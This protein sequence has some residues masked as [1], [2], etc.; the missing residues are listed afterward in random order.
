MPEE[1]T[2]IKDVPPIEKRSMVSENLD[3][4]AA[5][6]SVRKEMEK[7]D[8]MPNTDTLLLFAVEKLHDIAV[9]TSKIAE[10]VDIF[11]K[12]NMA[13]QVAPVQAKPVIPPVATPFKAVPVETPTDASPRLLE[14]MKALNK[15]KD[16][17]TFD[18]S[19]SA[20]YIFVK[21]IRKVDNWNEINQ[22]VKG[23]GGSYGE[24]KFTI[25]KIISTPTATPAPQPSVPIAN[26]T[27]I[28]K[29]KVNLKEFEDKLNFD[30]TVSSTVIII[31]P[32]A[33]IGSRFPEI[34]K[35]VKETLGG[36]YISDGPNSHFEVPK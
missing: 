28:E 25:P 29:V 22:I 31:K 8:F 6:D 17:L 32:K 21:T 35:I 11:K 19:T 18:E 3:I 2:Q 34:A 16:V 7:P 5:A 10:V 33:F 14:V 26:L 23:L 4:K 30:D 36:K 12:A 15:S 9:A 20:Q 24:Y 1:Q 13:T 27:A